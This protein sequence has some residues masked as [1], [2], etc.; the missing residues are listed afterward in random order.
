M[1]INACVRRSLVP[2]KMLQYVLVVIC[3]NLVS[4]RP[5]WNTIVYVHLCFLQRGRFAQHFVSWPYLNR[6]K[7]PGISMRTRTAGVTLAD[8]AAEVALLQFVRG[9]N[10]CKENIVWSERS[11]F[12]AI[13]RVIANRSRF[14][15]NVQQRVQRLVIIDKHAHEIAI[16]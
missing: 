7:H 1:D 15:I 8:F 14:P 9:S 6:C 4:K 5:Y 2:G 13:H 3:R 10:C 16:L 12:P 11:K